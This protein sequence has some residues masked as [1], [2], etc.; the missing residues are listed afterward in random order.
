[1]H[2]Y[3]DARWTFAYDTVK[4]RRKQLFRPMN[5]HFTTDNSGPDAHSSREEFMTNV[6]LVSLSSVSDVKASS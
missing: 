5:A 3:H 6:M 4:F 1:M 2:N